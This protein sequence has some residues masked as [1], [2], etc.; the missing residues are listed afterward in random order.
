MAIARPF[1]LLPQTHKYSSSSFRAK[2]ETTTPNLAVSG[3]AAV[4]LVPKLVRVELREIFS[5]IQSN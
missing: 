5:Y 2:S 3:A 1:Q 4:S